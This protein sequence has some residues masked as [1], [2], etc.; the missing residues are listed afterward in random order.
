MDV[1]LGNL[2]ATATQEDA[3]IGITDR[4]LSGNRTL[5][6]L[7]EGLDTYKIEYFYAYG[8][9]GLTIE[10]GAELTLADGVILESPDSNK[11]L[12]VNEG[13]KLIAG[14]AELQLGA[15]YMTVSGEA[16]LTGTTIVS[17]HTDPVVV[18]DGGKLTMTG[19]DL[20]GVQNR[21]HVYGGGW[22]QLNDMSVKQINTDGAVEL[23]NVSVEN[24]LYISSGT[25]SGSDVVFT[26]SGRV[27]ELNNVDVSLGNL[28]ATATQEDAYIGI[29][30][31]ELS[32]EITLGIL[33]EGLDTYSLDSYYKSLSIKSGGIL[34][35][36][37]GVTIG[38]VQTGADLSVS[39]GGKLVAG[40]AQLQMGT[41]RLDVY[42][43]AELTGTTI[44][45][46]NSDAMR[47]NSGGKVTMTCCDMSASQGLYVAGVDAILQL[48]EMSVSNISSYGNIDLQDVSVTG[49]LYIGNGTVSG[50]D[51]V[52]TGR[53]RVIDLANVDVNLGNLNATATQED[54]YIGITDSE[55]SGEVT[56]GILGEGLE[57][58][59]LESGLTINS[60]A[61]LTLEEDVKLVCPQSFRD[62]VVRAGGKLVA[63]EVVI[64]LGASDLD[65]YGEA[66]LTGTI[67]S[68]TQNSNADVL[69]VYN[70]GK[71]SMTGC[72][73]ENIQRVQ[74]YS[75]A[76][77]KADGCSFGSTKLTLAATSS[78]V[79]TGS[80]LSGATITISGT[81]GGDSLID[82]SGNY[83]GTTDM[84]AIWAR[85]SGDKSRVVIDDIVLVNPVTEFVY[86]E[87]S[88]RN[89]GI[90]ATTSQFEVRLSHE[91]DAE[92]VTDGTVRVL[93]AT[94][95]EAS[96]RIVAVEGKSI[97]IEVSGVEHAAE[98]RLVLADSICDVTGASL[99][100]LT[101]AGY[102]AE[103]HADFVAPR[104]AQVSPA[105][106]FAGTLE[107]LRLYFTDA[108][109]VS[110]LKKGVE[111]K[112]PEGQEIDI[113][114]V[115]DIGGNVYELTISPQ[116]SYG[117]YTLSVGTGVMDMAG[118]CLNQN[119]NDIF[120]ES[121]D[122]YV[123]T[124][125]ITEVDLTVRDVQVAR[126]IVLGEM[127]S[128]DW[129][130]ANASGYALHGSWTDGVYLST[131]NR[132]DINDI[133][134]GEY[135]HTG[136]LA[137]G[138][139]YTGQISAAVSGVLPGEY[140]LLVRSDTR[141][142]EQ[143]NKESA[144]VA[145]NLVAVPIT[146]A[147]NRLE[148]GSGEPYLG[149]LLKGDQQD[150][151]LLHQE[152]GQSLR[153]TLDCF[154]EL[155]NLEIFIGDGRVP[156]REAYDM[157][158]Q[159]GTNKGEILISG[160]NSTRDLYVLVNNKST[161]LEVEYGLQADVVPMSVSGITPTTQGQNSSTTF[162]ITGVNFSPETK[163][164]LVDAAGH[165][166]VP[167]MLDVISSGRIRIKYDA[168]RLPAEKLDVV[169]RS[170]DEEVCRNDAITITASTG[171]HLKIASFLPNV[172]GYHI[173]ST[174]KLL[175]ENTG[176]DAMHAPLLT[177][178]GKQNGK[179]GAIMTMDPSIV[180]QGFWT[181]AMP[182]GFSNSV[183][184]LA[185]SPGTPG[186]LMP[187]GRD[188][189]VE[190]KMNS[191]VSSLEDWL[192][193]RKSSN[194]VME[195]PGYQVSIVNDPEV[196]SKEP[197]S[198]YYFAA[199]AGRGMVGSR[200][201]LITSSTLDYLNSEAYYSQYLGNT[202]NI[203]YCGWQQPWDYSYPPFDFQIGYLGT[204]NTS[205]LNWYDSFSYTDMTAEHKQ[206]L[207]NSLTHSAGD[208]WGD[209]VLMLNQ[210]LIYLDEL[211]C[212][213]AGA[214]TMF[215]TDS[216]VEFELMKANGT[217]TPTRILASST[218]MS[219]AATGL[220]LGVSR[221]YMNNISSRF[222][223]G[224]FGYGWTHNWDV[225][226]SFR[227][228][229]TVV[230]EAA[231]EQRIYQPSYQGGYINASGDHAELK[232]NRDGS[233]TLTEPEGVVRSFAAEGDGCQWE[234]YF[235]R[236]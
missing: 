233:Y 32:G 155:A 10:S 82:L 21:L 80:D 69:D 114:Q 15:S 39:S 121:D 201:W 34:I 221:V 128:V 122:G 135:A 140:Y 226:L 183:S 162:D 63:G 141:G 107:T 13:G 118:N 40:A 25:V 29:T 124:F 87:T 120:G 88:L 211:G 115:T 137:E 77:F 30:D 198:K 192:W 84:D 109:D 225:K 136:G 205:S 195:G 222:Q 153:L 235:L 105:G 206:T 232:K 106:D 220:S 163:V 112:S 54:A 230:Y 60:G 175:Y 202:A 148:V 41:S 204:D 48:N 100:A 164:V 47:V 234:L 150:I 130:G 8:G 213:S 181:S 20:S 154:E 214:N 78:S 59:R 26:G 215:D 7:G 160:G 111:L 125:N 156:T 97:T 66:E 194:K 104:V 178:T 177:Y 228:D 157:A 103:L 23:Q 227:D 94:G 68:S 95:K 51:V 108:V 149:K 16:E 186:W 161:A 96:V 142:Q 116:T 73:V 4:Y 43:E 159:K 196:L 188:Q 81:S 49:R 207:A 144:A 184:F 210:N 3:Y 174:I 180:N 70:G 79:I 200:M 9:S 145:Q 14:A 139:S 203:Y 131:D 167:D 197:E 132:W 17:T 113:V 182:E 18:Y 62:L 170:G 126:E 86:R 24:Q 165:E 12:Y 190:D 50:S 31:S 110:T 133:L 57:T 138:E 179:E 91:I 218:D 75:G 102:A 52:F 208:T 168:K 89:N 61:E 53:G 65:I 55:L 85:I 98:Y 90:T 158:W 6:V 74:V 191:L 187:T 19:C 217:M 219:V 185:Y 236:L 72:D 99:A 129:S 76:E 28:R 173:M 92:T 119:G 172:L 37:D 212:V 44:A 216:L 67:I 134:L 123:A 166:Y 58:Y 45:S 71:M 38:G 224:A 46:T 83:W 56:L 2:N 209:Y 101:D 127:V 33:G 35:L 64:Q 147:A 146:V 169:V 22:L 93:D 199:A 36:E 117:Q 27:I 193:Y 42:G 171:A 176:T 229:G 151:V 5:G 11:H 223:T 189:A 1:S 231:G 152:A 143:T